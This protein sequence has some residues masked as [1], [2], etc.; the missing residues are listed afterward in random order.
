MFFRTC[1]ARMMMIKGKRKAFLFQPSTPQIVVVE[2]FFSLV[3]LFDPLMSRANPFHR[4]AGTTTRWLTD[5]LTALGRQG[6]WVS[7]VQTYNSLAME[8]AVAKSAVFHLTT[9][10]SA[11]AKGGHWDA[12]A[13]TFSF[14]QRSGMEP[15]VFTYTSLITACGNAGRTDLACRAY[16]LMQQRQ[17]RATVP[18][19]TAMI[20]MWARARD[21]PRALALLYDAEHD[22]EPK[23]SPNVKSYTA[24]IDGCR[25]AARW[26]AAIRLLVHM[27]HQRAVT[28]ND[29]TYNNVLNACGEAGNWQAAI[30]VAT[31]M[32]SAGYVLVPFSMQCLE[33][34]TRGEGPSNAPPAELVAALGGSESGVVPPVVA[35]GA[36]GEGVVA[37][38]T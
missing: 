9:V 38:P 8:P 26:D 34:S 19:T 18:V 31:Q 1:V 11:C 32:R 2:R 7:A 10:I 22:D 16:A 3:T 4:L 17:V 27:E 6:S 33:R 29:V 15:N 30:S 5:E 28:A 25:R 37:P 35:P 36:T 13:R 24:A 12:A 21:W 20:A 23:N 14:M